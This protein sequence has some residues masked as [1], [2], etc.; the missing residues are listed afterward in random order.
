[1]NCDLCGS[2]PCCCAPRRLVAPASEAGRSVVSP[3]SGVRYYLCEWD[4]GCQMPVRTNPAGGG[5]TLC[6]WHVECL[7]AEHPAQAAGHFE[8]FEAWL[9]GIQARYP[10]RGFWSWGAGRLWPIIQGQQ[11]V[12]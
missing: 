10:S 4:G 3:V 2:D 11:G 8:A 12:W 5:D 1:M 6:R 9:V 7:R